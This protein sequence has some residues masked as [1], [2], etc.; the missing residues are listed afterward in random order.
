MR[1]IKNGGIRTIDIF[2]AR[3]ALTRTDSFSIQ[4]DT[5]PSIKSF[6]PVTYR[7]STTRFDYPATTIDPAIFDLRT[8]KKLLGVGEYGSGR[9][10]ALSSDGSLFITSGGSKF[11][12]WKYD[13]GRY[14]MWREYP[15][16]TYPAFR[17]LFSPN[18][19]SILGHSGDTL[20]LWRLD[21]PSVAPPALAQQLG[22]FSC[23]GTYMA[24][25]RRGGCTITITNIL[26][27]NTSFFID[28]DIEVFEL[29]FTGNVLLVV[30][31][32]AVVAWLSTEWGLVDGTFGNR[33]AG[34]GDSVWTASISQSRAWDPI[35]S[36]EGEHAVIKSDGDTPHIYNTRTGEVL[37]P[38]QA[39]LRS[40][41][42]WY[43]LVDTNQAR[44]HFY[45][46]SARNASIEDDWGPSG[47]CFEEG[48]VKDREGRHLLWLPSE[49]RVGEG[50]RVQ[51]FSNTAT[52]RFIL[53]GEPVTI[54]LY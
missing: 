34:R 38:A 32:G 1:T 24:T 36:V 5:G 9:S 2:E 10:H 3:P 12:I 37:E 31:S 35:F 30:G 26:S 48:W 43:S 19:Q 40:D 14:I 20:R 27:Q 52:M 4:L 49:W 39:P 44:D 28:T 15:I 47:T 53:W 13:T 29:G 18:S 8:S 17:Y 11:L 22:T 23:C 54:K 16:P 41:G 45:K 50:H 6:S 33:R 51:W 21:G 42:P 7:V 46:R 25:T